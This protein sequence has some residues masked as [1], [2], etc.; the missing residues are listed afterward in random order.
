M[1]GVN[2]HCELLGAKRKKCLDL[3]VREQSKKSNRRWK[4]EES[5]V[6]GSL[7]DRTQRNRKV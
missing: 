4:R 7:Q 5:I 1:N 6:T 3:E 2:G